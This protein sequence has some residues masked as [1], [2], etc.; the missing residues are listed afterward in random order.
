MVIIFLVNI[1]IGSNYLM[2][3]GRPA[4]ASLLDLLPDWP[5]YILYM[6][7]IGAVCCLLL[8]LPFMVKD[9]RM[10]RAEARESTKRLEKIAK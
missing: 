6:E 9:W 2:I 7:A 8:Y 3:N 1:A 5:V 4:T 10:K